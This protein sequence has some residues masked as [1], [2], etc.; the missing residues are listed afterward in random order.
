MKLNK[1]SKAL[2]DAEQCTKLDPA[3]AKGWFRR[4]QASGRA[5]EG[6]QG[7]AGQPLVL[8]ARLMRL[9]LECV[10]WRM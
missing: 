6:G 8:P 3:N 7:E 10:R 9:H 4:A 1:L 2:S 5:G